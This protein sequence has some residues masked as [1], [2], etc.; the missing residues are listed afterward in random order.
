[1]VEIKIKKMYNDTIL[2]RKA[3]DTD[4]CYDIYAW[5]DDDEPHFIYPHD[6][7]LI[8]T[9]FC[10]EIPVGYWGAIFA[11]SGL[12]TK[13]GLRPAQ[14]VPVIDA[15]YR[16]SWKIPLHNDT[17]DTKTIRKGD[18][19]CQFMILPVIPTT[20]VSTEELTETERGEGG[21]GASG[22]R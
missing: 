22:I 21:F 9:G 1:M 16:G 7:L 8:D 2:P 15:D 14:G 6:T 10:T 5:F 12:A 17:N 20:L 3:H 13:Q 11:R 4:A 18:R 19:I